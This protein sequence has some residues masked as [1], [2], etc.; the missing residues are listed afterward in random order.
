MSHKARK[1]YILFIVL[2][3]ILAALILFYYPIR[4]YLI[5]SAYSAY[6]NK[7]SVMHE[8]GFE[9]DMKG[10]LFTA[11]KDWYPFVN[12]YDT[13]Y[14][15]SKYMDEV[16][17]LTV[18]YNFGAF[19]GKSSLLFD[20]G[21]IYFAAFYGA[22]A[23]FSSEN[24]Q[25]VY[26]F[27]NEEIDIEEISAV[28]MFDYK[29]LVIEDMGCKDPTLELIS[30]KSTKDISYAGYEGWIQIDA[31]M[32]ASSPVHQRQKF[33]LG[34]IQ[35]GKPIA[36]EKGDF[37]ETELFGRMYV[38]YF[39][40]YECTVVLYIMGADEEVINDCDTEILNKTIIKDM[41]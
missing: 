8:K 33:K 19:D 41:R 35:Y 6:N 32:H 7:D 22:Y 13:S 26:G 15:F 23:I 10:G 12:I 24:L 3:A 38:R 11:K 21:S 1:K 39:E 5:M 34:Y 40:E 9:I 16:L 25:R 2:A 29:Y 14:E 20:E 17:R 27:N 30:Y 18:V 31:L 37:Y 4:S 36:S 28:P